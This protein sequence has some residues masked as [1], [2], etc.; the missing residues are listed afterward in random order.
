[1]RKDKCMPDLENHGRR[2]SS[3]IAQMKVKA[4]YDWG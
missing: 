4:L 1:M 2:L 3:Q